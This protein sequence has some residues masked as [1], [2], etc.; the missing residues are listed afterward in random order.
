MII[1]ADATAAAMARYQ[2][3]GGGSGAGSS[4]S[5]AMAAGE[6]TPVLSMS[7]ETTRFLGQDYVSTEQLQ[8]A[9][10]AT[11]RRATTAGAKAGAAQVSSQMRNSPGYR[12]Q[13]GL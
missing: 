7:F 9:M 6:A 10:A 5:D 11:E 8:A 12:R 3:Q 4:S 13:V 2:R 1:P